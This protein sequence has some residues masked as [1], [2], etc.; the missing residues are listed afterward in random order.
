MEPAFYWYVTAL[1]AVALI[2]SYRMPDPSKDGYLVN[3]R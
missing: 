2:V 1:C 3:A